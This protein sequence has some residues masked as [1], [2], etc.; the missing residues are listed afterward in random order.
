[1]GANVKLGSMRSV[2]LFCF[3]FFFKKKKMRVQSTW[4]VRQS[5]VD[6]DRPNIR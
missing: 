1:M 4:I 3:V 2:L 6:S 5:H